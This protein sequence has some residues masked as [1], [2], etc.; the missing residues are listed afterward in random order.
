MKALFITTKTADCI[1]HVSAWECAFGKSEQATFNHEGIRNDHVILEAAQAAK[2]DVIF[3]I[4]AIKGLG[5][6]RPETYRALRKIAPCINIC[7]D[8]ADRPWHPVLETYDRMKLFDLQV[9]IDGP[10]DAPVDLSTLTPVDIRPFGAD[11]KKDIRFGFSGSVGR[12]NGRSEIV[13]ALEWL[14]GLTVR[15]RAGGY[16]DHVSFLKRCRIVLNVSLTGS[17]QRHHIKGRVLEAGW[18]GCALL[19]SAGS[20]IGNWFP[21]DCYLIYNDPK[22]AAEIARDIDDATIESMAKRL[23]EEVRER[24]HPKIIYADMLKRAMGSGRGAIKQP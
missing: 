22:E 4:G 3:Y 2:P 24:F 12:W 19:E 15:H 23:A 5:N 1:N 11:V 8:S 17:G 9:G 6:P 10:S 21:S 14:G 7:S 20:T 18:A 13:K 16:E